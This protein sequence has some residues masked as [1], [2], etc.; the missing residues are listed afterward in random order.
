MIALFSF[1]LALFVSPFKSKSRLAAENAVIRQQ[2][3]ILRRKARDRVQLTNGDRLSFTQLEGSRLSRLLTLR[4]SCDGTGPAFAVCERWVYDPYFQHFTGQEFLQHEFPHE[5]GPK[6]SAPRRQAW[7]RACGWR[8]ATLACR[9]DPLAVAAP[10]RLEAVFL[11]RFR[12]GVHRQGQGQRAY[13]FSVKASV[14][15]TNARAPGGQFVLH[16]RTLP[17]NPY[18]GHTLGAVIKV[19]ERLTGPEIERA[20]VDKG[21]PQP[22]SP[23]RSACSSQANNAGSSAAS[24]ANSRGAPPSTR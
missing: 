16:A 15:T 18:D 19:T 21:V 17:G 4:P 9:S 8:L 24:K 3:I 22:R 14:V 10:A 20:Y 5:L 1:L 11:P 13:E 2:L 7:P 6:P 23:K 12:G